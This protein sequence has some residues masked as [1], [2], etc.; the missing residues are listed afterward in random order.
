[1]SVSVKNDQFTIHAENP[2]LKIQVTGRFED[3]KKVV[4][5]VRGTRDGVEFI[6]KD[7]EKLSKPD[8]E[9]VEQLLK[10]VAGRVQKDK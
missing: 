9:V 2:D 6:A 8:R 4:E 10:H 3:G 7:L 5:E 1:M